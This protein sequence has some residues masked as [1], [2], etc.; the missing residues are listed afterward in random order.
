MYI[1]SHFQTSIHR[2]NY[3][4]CFSF[5]P[6]SLLILFF[7][8]S[9]IWFPTSIF[10]GLDNFLN[11]LSVIKLFPI[12]TVSLYIY[13]VISVGFWYFLNSFSLKYFVFVV[14]LS[15]SCSW[16]LKLILK[17]KIIR[18]NI[19]SFLKP[20]SIETILI[21]YH[22]DIFYYYIS[23]IDSKKIVRNIS[24]PWSILLRIDDFLVTF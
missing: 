13:I 15:L 18:F 20:Q 1:L 23:A 14:L 11:F 10:A 16:T 5:L 24:C 17:E 2:F 12:I 19:Y 9:V 7:G 3:L 22:L 6:T 4:Y 8:S 21:Y